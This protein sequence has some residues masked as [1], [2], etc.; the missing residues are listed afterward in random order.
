[1]VCEVNTTAPMSSM[2]LVSNSPNL[3]E[4]ESKLSGEEDEPPLSYNFDAKRLEIWIK[5]GLAVRSHK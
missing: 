2:Q 1:M 5:V 4:L 3:G